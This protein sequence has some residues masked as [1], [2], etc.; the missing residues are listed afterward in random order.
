MF[1]PFK[2]LSL[3]RSY[4]L[5]LKKLEKHYFEAQ[6]KCHPDQ[7]SQGNE[8]EKA[9]ALQQST[10]VN[11]AYQLLKNPLERAEYLLKEAGIDTVATDPS[12]L[13]KVML[14]N[15]R[16]E[17]GEDVTRELLQEEKKG[18][19]ELEKAFTLKDYEKARSTFYQLNYSKN[20]LKKVDNK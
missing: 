20:L 18:L 15:E 12:F 4:S 8:Q 13:E 6:K 10:T 1:D 3:E 7:F 19:Q 5:D 2:I 16:L 11:Q 9:D 17:K 14:W